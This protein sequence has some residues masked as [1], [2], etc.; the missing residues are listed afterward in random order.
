LLVGGR[1]G[2]GRDDEPRQERQVSILLLRCGDLFLRNK[3]KQLLSGRQEP[4][5]LVSGNLEKRMPVGIRSSKSKE[6]RML[7]VGGG[8]TELRHEVEIRQRRM[9]ADDPTAGWIVEQIF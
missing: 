3:E 6:E 8:D 9:P 1:E 7:S 4:I 5:R 2:T